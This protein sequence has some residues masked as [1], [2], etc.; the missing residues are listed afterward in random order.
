MITYYEYSTHAEA[1]LTTRD[2]TV[3]Y[4]DFGHGN[5]DA[6]RAWAESIFDNK[7]TVFQK[8]AIV[9]IIFTDAETAEI[10][11]ICENDEAENDDEPF[12]DWDYNEDMG[13]DP[14][15]GCYTDDC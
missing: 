8:G 12:E 9:K 13:Y 4:T 1:H 10:L 2:N 7:N 5:L 14:Y 15:L 6:M 11:L 3:L